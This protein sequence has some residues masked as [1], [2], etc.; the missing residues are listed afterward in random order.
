MQKNDENL[1]YCFLCQ[2]LGKVFFGGL[3][4]TCPGCDGSG[5]LAE[6]E[7]LTPVCGECGQTAHEDKCTDRSK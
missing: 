1:P 2:T 3:E 5:Y 6:F 7:E 4:L